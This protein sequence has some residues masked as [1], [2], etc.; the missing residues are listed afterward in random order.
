MY[1]SPLL[2]LRLEDADEVVAG[3]DDLVRP[4]AEAHDEG[5]V[6]VDAVNH[7]LDAVGD[8][9]AE[10]EDALARSLHEVVHAV[11]IA[12]HEVLDLVEGGHGDALL[13]GELPVIAVMSAHGLVLPWGFVSVCVRRWPCGG[14]PSGR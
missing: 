11:G 12:A 10:D 13:L 4:V 8:V 9:A 2:D 5:R 6:A 14:V 7:H 3:A 1:S